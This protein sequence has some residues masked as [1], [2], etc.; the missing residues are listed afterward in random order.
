MIDERWSM[1]VPGL[2]HSREAP[3]LS[4]FPEAAIQNHSS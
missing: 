3:P 2:D 1:N 4:A